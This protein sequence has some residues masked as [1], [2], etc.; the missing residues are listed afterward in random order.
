MHRS[1]NTQSRS[2]PASTKQPPEL[3]HLMLFHEIRHG[4]WFVLLLR[5]CH[6]P[7][8]MP[9]KTWRIHAPPPRA[10]ISACVSGKY[11]VL[12]VKRHTSRASPGGPPP[13]SKLGIWCQFRGLNPMSLEI[14]L[15]GVPLTNFPVKFPSSECCGNCPKGTGENGPLVWW[16]KK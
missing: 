14:Q 2:L 1:P 12:G 6:L 9:L 10:T 8:R 13:N 4:L 16:A 3:A 5:F 7:R 15:M 11:A